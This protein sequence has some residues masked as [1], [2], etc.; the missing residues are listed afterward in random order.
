MGGGTTCERIAV[1]PLLA[2]SGLTGML[3]RCPLMRTKRTLAA[4][5]NLTVK[6]GAVLLAAGDSRRFGSGNKLLAEMADYLPITTAL[7]NLRGICPDCEALIHRRV[8]LASLCAFRAIPEMAVTQ[9]PARIMD[10]A[11][12]SL[13]CDLKLGSEANENA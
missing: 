2:Q 4:N 6:I 13:N 8:S 11:V 10:S 1:G 5:S 3:L 9:A 12:P 7:G